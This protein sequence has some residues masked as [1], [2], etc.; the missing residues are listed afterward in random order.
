[1]LDISAQVRSNG[2]QDLYT[3]VATVLDQ[4]MIKIDL[5][6]LYLSLANSVR[7][8]DNIKSH[9]SQFTPSTQV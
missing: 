3:C 6:F 7:T 9:D 8:Y 2:G 4:V 5:N 1:M